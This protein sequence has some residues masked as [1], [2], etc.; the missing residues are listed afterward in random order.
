MLRN[1][2]RICG[3]ST[4]AGTPARYRATTASLSGIEITPSANSSRIR[5]STLPAAGCGG[6]RVSNSP[7]AFAVIV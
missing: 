3:I 6:I 2:A 5:Y 1:I 7:S 4:C